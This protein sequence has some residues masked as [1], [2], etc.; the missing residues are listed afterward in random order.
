M[1]I[2]NDYKNELSLKPIKHFDYKYEERFYAEREIT[3]PIC[4]CVI[5]SEC[6]EYDEFYNGFYNILYGNFNNIRYLCNKLERK[7]DIKYKTSEHHYC[8]KCGL[9]FT[10]NKCAS[11]KMGLLYSPNFIEK[12]KFNNKIYSGMPLPTE[13]EYLEICLNP[14][15]FQI[16]EIKNVS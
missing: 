8:K 11:T 12:F 9:L 16:L 7:L 5:N 6:D 10:G 13:K 15:K 1:K 3:C 4:K 14:N 2:I